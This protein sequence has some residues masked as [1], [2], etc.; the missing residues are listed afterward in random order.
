MNKKI[1][2]KFFIISQ[3]LILIC[4]LIFLGWIYYILY[5]DNKP[6][7][8]NSLGDK[9]FTQ[10]PTTLIIDLNQPDED[11]LTF[12]SSILIS[13]K[14]I[15]SVEVLI[16]NETEDFVVKSKA[17]GNFSATL[18]LIEGVNRIEAV[19][20]DENGQSKSVKRTI[21]YSKEKI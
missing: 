18:D 20:F 19:V 10:N 21:F 16:I 1:S 6:P 4:A 13:G 5:L 11:A 12:E 9:L 7:S 15:P 3:I 17:D 14:T 2:T 8:S